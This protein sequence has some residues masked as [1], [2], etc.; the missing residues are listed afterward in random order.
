MIMMYSINLAIDDFKVVALFTKYFCSQSLVVTFYY[1]T[2]YVSNELFAIVIGTP[3]AKLPGTMTPNS[4]NR[5]YSMTW[6]S[7]SK[8]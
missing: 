1:I 3:F 5:A 4:Q 8:W 6:R 2:E 7:S